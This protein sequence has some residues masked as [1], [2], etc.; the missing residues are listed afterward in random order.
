MAKKLFFLFLLFAACSNPPRESEYK[1]QKVI[2]G[3]T[4][5]LANGR[6]LRY[7][8]IDTPE[9][10]VKNGD[11]F[12][13]S[14]QPFALEAKEY[15]QSLVFGKTIKVEYDVEKQ[16]RYGRLLGYCFAD[17]VFVNAKLLEEGYAVIYTYPPNIKYSDLFYKLQTDA[18]KKNRGLWGSYQVINSENA[19][20]YIGQIRTVQ[21]SVK[22]THKSAKCVSLN[23]G[24]DWR[25]DFT[26]V[27]FN[28]S[29]DSFRKKGINPLSFYQGKLVEVTGR[30]REYNGPEIIVNTPLE[31][32]IINNK[33]SY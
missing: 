32:E 33:S 21:G 7:I 31:I 12:I 11:N 18:R 25:T 13:Y 4:I 17:G 20:S 14:P 15:N 29:M 16:D 6:L 30:I 10:R 27:I 9:I 23:F 19:Q 1:V 2:D 24:D 28:N 8:G 5:R 22:S 3:D 26:V